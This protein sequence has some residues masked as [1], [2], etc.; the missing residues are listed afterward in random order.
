MV[1]SLDNIIGRVTVVSAGSPIQGPNVLNPDGFFIKNHS[2]NSGS[3]YAYVMRSG[4]TKTSSMT[5][6]VGE[7]MYFPVGNLNMLS[8]DA[9][10]GSTILCYSRV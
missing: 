8:F 3:G 7:V 9:D 6:D 2:G 5:L 1:F 10:S 4:S